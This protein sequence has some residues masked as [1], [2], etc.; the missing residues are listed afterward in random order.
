MARS[1]ARAIV[2]LVARF[3]CCSAGGCQPLLWRARSLS[4]ITVRAAPQS[5]DSYGGIRRARLRMGGGRARAPAAPRLS[6]AWQL[7]L[8]ATTSTTATPTIG[9]APVVWPCAC[10]AQWTELN[11]SRSCPATCH[12]KCRHKR[13]ALW[14]RCMRTF[15]MELPL[16][17]SQLKT[18]LWVIPRTPQR[19]SS[20][21]SFKT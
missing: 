12:A 1:M 4:R 3:A 9:R 6:R 17:A 10:R 7:R 16:L 15:A 19:A 2:V 14:V 11:Y 18:I 20:T 8:H 5:T 21:S 13:F